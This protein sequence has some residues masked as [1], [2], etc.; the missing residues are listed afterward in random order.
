MGGTRVMLSSCPSPP[1]LDGGHRSGWGLTWATRESIPS[2][3]VPG[4]VLP[5]W[6]PS[7]EPREGTGG[8]RTGQRQEQ[9]S[10]GCGS[11]GQAAP[12]PRT[13]IT[14]SVFHTRFRS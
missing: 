7:G 11:S 12:P 10:G 5:S 14:Q 1:S 4:S 13:G 3:S 2:A 8:L 6:E 9:M